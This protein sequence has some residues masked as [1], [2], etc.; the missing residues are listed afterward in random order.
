MEKLKSEKNSII[1]T[2]IFYSV[3]ILWMLYYFFF[4]ILWQIKEIEVKKDL[5]YKIYEKIN[6]V[7]KS[8]I[9]YEEFKKE[10]ENIIW[11]RIFL[12]EIV[13][14]LSNDFYNNNLINDKENTFDIFIKNKIEDLNS[15]ENKKIIEENNNKISKILPTYSDKKINNKVDLF[16]DFQFINYI[17]SIL[18][19]FNLSTDSPIGIKNIYLLSDYVN[20]S[21]NSNLID[22]NIY[23]IPISLD[24]NWN[25]SSIIEFLYFIENVGNI[26]IKE[27]DILINNN[28]WFLSKNTSKRV[29]QWDKLSLNY[30]IFENQIIDVENVLFSKYIDDSYISRWEQDFKEFIIKTQW[31]DKYILKIDLLFYVKWLPIYQLKDFIT[32]ILSKY[33]EV[34]TLLNEKLKNTTKNSLEYNK[35][36][37]YK[38]TLEKLNNK[39]NN[40]KKN[41]NDTTKIDLL[42][43]EIID[44]ELIINQI[45]K[46]INK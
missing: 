18:E 1:I 13:N 17:E 41:L 23:Y 45:N 27:K 26:S 39:I 36:L 16:T 8:G 46:F 6:K 35:I 12:K 9:S 42:Y 44:I 40:I 5:T 34:L 2:L 11:D 28:Y 7:K 33:K 29:L 20:D 4:V 30:N 37:S 24:L 14:A 32:W 38:N 10:S 22:S 15:I 3:I 21:K 43:E 31:N 25:K 19:T